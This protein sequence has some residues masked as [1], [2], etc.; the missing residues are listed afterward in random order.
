MGIKVTLS[1]ISVVALDLLII[2]IPEEFFKFLKECLKKQ[3]LFQVTI[4]EDGVYQL[5][6]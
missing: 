6:S 4:E 2:L 3:F 1:F 5:G